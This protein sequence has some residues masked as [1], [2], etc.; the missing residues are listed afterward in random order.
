MRRSELARRRRLHL[1]AGVADAH[2]GVATRGRLLEVGLSRSDIEGEIN[3][4]RWHHLGRHTV[5]VHMR[6]PTGRARWWWA[7][8][9]AGPGA[10]VDGVTSLLAHGLDHWDEDVVHVSVPGRNRVHR[11]PGVRV[12]RLRDVGRTVVAGVPRTAPEVAVLRAAEWAGT[13]RQAATLL[14]MT[15]QQRLVSPAWV[16]S[17][18]STVKRS[19]RRAFLDRVV[20]DVCAGAE[21]LGELDFAALCRRRGLPPPTRQVVRRGPRGRIYLDVWWEEYG[22]NVEIDGAQHG[23]G[24][25]PVDDALRQNHVTLTGGVCLRIPLLG[26]RVQPDA[27]LEQVEAALAAAGYR[28]APVR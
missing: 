14:A 18:W 12:H 2:D 10:V 15:V 25:A 23:R 9:E 19:R 11:L 7:M 1:A 16:L 3:A 13:D 6:R 24:L 22:V 4:G 17:R 26:L 28:P 27:F 20:K 21:S 8:W 5:G